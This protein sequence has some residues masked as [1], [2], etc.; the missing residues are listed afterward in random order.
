MLIRRASISRYVLHPLTRDP[1]AV[2]RRSEECISTDSSFDW[3]RKKLLPDE[4]RWKPTAYRIIY[5][6]TSVC[7]TEVDDR[8]SG[9]TAGGHKSNSRIWQPAMFKSKKR[10]F[11]RSKNFDVKEQ[12]KIEYNIRENERRKLATVSLFLYSDKWHRIFCKRPDW[13]PVSRSDW[14]D[15]LISLPPTNI[16]SEFRMRSS[17]CLIVAYCLMLDK[18]FYW[19]FLTACHSI[20]NESGLLWN[21]LKEIP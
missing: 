5:G 19:V 18:D 21:S 1:S 6:L 11:H 9:D 8:P 17:H 2:K 3:L 4:H 13:T 15:Y 14:Q 12:P 16:D 10:G 20:H 7:G